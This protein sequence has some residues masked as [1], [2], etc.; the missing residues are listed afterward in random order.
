MSKVVART[1]CHL[2]NYEAY[3]VPRIEE[4]QSPIVH[5]MIHHG[6]R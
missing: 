6:D 4:L 3:R 2:L 1:P 5:L